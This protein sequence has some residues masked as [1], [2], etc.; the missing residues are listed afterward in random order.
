MDKPA[1]QPGVRQPDGVCRVLL[2]EDDGPLRERFARL[3]AAWPGGQLVAA[4]ATLGQALQA[5]QGGRIDLLITDLRLPDGHGTQAIRLLR[6]LHPQAEAMVISVLADDATVIEAIEAGAAGYLLKD[7]D[8]I[9]LLEAIE[10]LRA[11]R[12]PISSSIAR[13]IVRRLGAAGADAP[14]VPPAEAL[15]PRE[16]E[17]LWG[18][19][20]GLT[21]AELAQQLG[22]SRQT[23]PVHIKNV[24]R[25]LEA[26]NR[27]EAVF[28]ASRNGLIRL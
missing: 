9:E 18:I 10:E 21:Y 22:I 12:S 7:A 26:T 6:S 8:S 2:V 15:T 25:K 3:L 16:T 28:N 23:V 20:R 1:Q 5:L 24:Y 11:G 13:V 14:A 17:I 19:A 27:S 4:C